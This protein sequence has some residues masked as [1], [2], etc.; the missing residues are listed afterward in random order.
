MLTAAGTFYTTLGQDC[1]T[2]GCGVD[3]FLFPNAYI[4]VAS[5]GEVPR[6]TG[7]DIYRYEYFTV[8]PIMSIFTIDSIMIIYKYRCLLDL[9]TIWLFYFMPQ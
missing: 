3:L 9:N 7:G 1:V 4:D 8:S 2:H 6:L 5:I